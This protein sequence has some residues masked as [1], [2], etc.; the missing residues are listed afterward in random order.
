M[1][2]FEYEGKKTF[3]KFGIPVP[4]SKLVDN[5]EEAVDYF[6]DLKKSCV[7][8][9]QVLSGK[10]GKA[11][12]IQ[13]ADNISELKSN[14][15]KVKNMKIYGENVSSV[16][17][18]E[19]ISIEN[20]FYMGITIDPVE[21]APV[22]IFSLEGGMNIEDIAEKYPEKIIK[23]VIDE[24]MHLYNYCDILSSLNLS[25]KLI[26]NI[27]KIAD[28]LVSLF[29][30]VDATTVE[31]NPLVVTDKKDVLAADSKLV[32]D[33]SALFRQKDLDLKVKDVLKSDLEKQA[34]KYKLNY[35][36]LDKSGN[37]GSIAGGAGLAMA[38]MDTIRYCGGKPANFLDIGGGVS[39]NNM[40]E[41][42]NIVASQKNVEGIL[43]NV[44]GGINNCEYM[45]KGIKRAIKEYQ[46]KQK[47]V[48][49]MRGHFQEEGWKIL[50]DLNI[51]TVKYDT[52]KKAVKVLLNKLKEE[53]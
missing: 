42:L 10:R 5:Q 34:E 24:N 44:F 16:L 2:C 21:K 3:K 53:A 30:S 18:E 32:I 15:N 31:I 41:A 48:V 50:S 6:N 9:A 11:G 33:D 27:S 45:A 43:V 29:F 39:E 7:I 25:N 23:T 13:F 4:Q 51:P 12:G 8:K 19:K 52:T 38:T 35:V 26:M 46:I 36:L 1:K 14:F 40:A 17:L 22:L 20:E 28:K 47:I 49:K 37:I